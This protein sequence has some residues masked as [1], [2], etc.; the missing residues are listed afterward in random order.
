MTH[1]YLFVIRTSTKLK[2]YGCRIDFEK[3]FNRPR[4]EGLIQDVLFENNIDLNYDSPEYEGYFAKAIDYYQELEYKSALTCINIVIEIQLEDDWKPYAIKGDILETLGYFDEA[5]NSYTSAIEFHHYDVEAYALYHQIGF[6]YL[7]SHSHEDAIRIISIAIDSK[8]YWKNYGFKKDM[9]VINFGV[10]YGLPFK[11]LYVNRA[12]AYLN[13][14]NLLKAR[15]DALEALKYDDCYSNAYLLISQIFAMVGKDED[16]MRLLT[17]AAE[18]G[19]NNASTILS[20]GGF[21]FR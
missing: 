20:N 18:L 11:Q 9:E 7:L 10:L 5:I 8:S 4:R 16:S 13:I 14:G 12:N 21:K 15:A 17:H 6:C 2:Y 1:E 19:N 3:A